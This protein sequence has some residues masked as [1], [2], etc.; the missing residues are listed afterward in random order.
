MAKICDNIIHGIEDK[1]KVVEVP[2]K[3]G[4]GVI[5][6]ARRQRGEFICEYSGEL[7]TYNVEKQRE[8]LYETVGCFTYYFTHK[9]IKYWYV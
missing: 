9:N 6:T 2:D 8:A 5:T 1:L 3:G 4:K 7:V